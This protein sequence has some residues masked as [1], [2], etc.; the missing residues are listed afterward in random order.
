MADPVDL[1][2]HVTGAQ[3]AGRGPVGQDPGEA[4]AVLAVGQAERLPEDGIGEVLPGE[5]ATR[6]AAPLSPGPVGHEALEDGRGDGRPGVAGA[7]GEK[8]N[9]LFVMDH[10]LRRAQ[11]VRAGGHVQGQQVGPRE[12]VP[13]RADLTHAARVAVQEPGVPPAQDRELALARQRV[14]E[15]ERLEALPEIGVVH[16]DEGQRPLGVGEHHPPGGARVLAQL[17]HLDEQVVSEGGG[18]AEDAAA[19]DDEPGQG[20]GPGRLLGPGRL[21]VPLLSAHQHPDDARPQV[22]VERRRR[23]HGRGAGGRLS[24][25]GGR[26]FRGGRS[27]LRGRRLPVG[28]GL[29]GRRGLLGSQGQAAPEHQ[30]RRAKNGQARACGRG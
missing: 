13:A 3:A 30:E 23:G 1:E 20:A 22:A 21:P 16:F 5:A 25:L 11:A 7:P 2:D 27:L 9:D 8:A 15:G 6:E 26:G 18:G 28:R 10:H 12:A 4:D 29:P 14:G 19:G 17:L 24:L